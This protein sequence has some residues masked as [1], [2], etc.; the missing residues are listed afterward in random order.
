[1]IA[2]RKLLGFASVAL[3]VFGPR[4]AAQRAELFTQPQAD[5]GHAVYERACT[6]C[7]GA[8][9]NG[10]EPGDVPALAGERFDHSWRGEPLQALFDKVSKTMP[11]NRPGALTPAEYADIIAYLLQANGLPSGPEELRADAS[12]LRSVIPPLAQRTP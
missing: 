2:P 7:H 8:D 4:A 5:R 12:A 9:L 10:D 6:S 1:M 11:A 3:L